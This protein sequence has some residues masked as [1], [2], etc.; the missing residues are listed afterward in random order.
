MRGRQ[1]ADAVV[2]GKMHG[3]VE[4]GGV[5]QHKHVNRSERRTNT[6]KTAEA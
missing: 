1:K 4:R 2:V 3:K 5:N 6:W